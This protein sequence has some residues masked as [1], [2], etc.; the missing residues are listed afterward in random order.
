MNQYILDKL[1]K[2]II[3]SMIHYCEIE[4]NN[5]YL[6]LSKDNLVVNEST[7][8]VKEIGKNINIEYLFLYSKLY[9]KY[10]FLP[11]LIMCNFF[12]FYIDGKSATLTSSLI[13]FEDIITN[14]ET[15]TKCLMNITV[16]DI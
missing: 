16:C 8:N 15:N 13:T 7:K 2:D 12:F 6:A 1:R 14:F 3:V 9:L 10:S 4:K 5:I 11:I